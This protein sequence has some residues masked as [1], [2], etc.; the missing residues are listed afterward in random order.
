MPK[1]GEALWG[2]NLLVPWC[3]SCLALGVS[4]RPGCDSEGS[5][6]LLPAS[7][8][9]VGGGEGPVCRGEGMGKKLNL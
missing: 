7:E 6:V 4:G 8:A 3:L 1:E 9:L 2:F 5:C